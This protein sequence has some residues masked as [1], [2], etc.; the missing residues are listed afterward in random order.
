MDI[1]NFC[2]QSNFWTTVDS[3]FPLQDDIILKQVKNA[4]I[5]PVS[6]FYN[7]QRSKV[8]DSF[9]L[10]TKRCYNSDEIVCPV[11]DG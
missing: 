5:L 6:E 8:L 10:T 1:I 11:P 3:W 9:M 4:I 2:H 7:I